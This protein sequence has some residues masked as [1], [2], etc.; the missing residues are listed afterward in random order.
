MSEA[1]APWSA[2]VTLA[3]VDRGPVT[4][5]LAPDAQARAGLARML[6]LVALDKLEA[7]VRLAPWLDGAELT[8]DW[9][10][11]IVQTCGLSLETFDTVLE[12]A[13][14]VRVV[15]PG[16]LHAPS[17]EAEIDLDPD[18]ED[19]PDLLEGTTIDAAAY[20]VEQLALEIDPFPR[21]PGIEFEPPPPD[22]VPSPFAVLAAR[23]SEPKA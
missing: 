17:A 2:S 8:A 23:W 13:F 1:G 7:E 6:D 12:G 11:V 4:L 19:S 16:S 15:P 5:A 9:R 3:E 10:A 14:T 21:K 18:A 20:V 22:E